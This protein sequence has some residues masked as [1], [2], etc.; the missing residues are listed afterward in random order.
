MAGGKKFAY[1]SS[2]RVWPIVSAFDLQGGPKLSIM[3]VIRG[4][5]LVLLR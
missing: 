2:L 5:S 3:A 1:L 4:P